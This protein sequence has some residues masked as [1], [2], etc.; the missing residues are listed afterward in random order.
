M[1]EFAVESRVYRHK[2]RKEAQKWDAPHL[3]ALSRFYWLFL[4]DFGPTP[5]AYR[6]LVVYVPCGLSSFTTRKPAD[7]TASQ[8]AFEA[9]V[10]SFCGTT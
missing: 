2:K 3:R 5:T 1:L 9:T 6:G 7:S 8:H 10:L 4:P